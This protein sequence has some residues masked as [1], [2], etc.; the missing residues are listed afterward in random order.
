MNILH[1]GVPRVRINGSVD[2]KGGLIVITGPG[3]FKRRPNTR[4]SESIAS[5][6]LMLSHGQ[7][8]GKG[9]LVLTLHMMS[10]LHILFAKALDDGQP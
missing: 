5:R 2:K 6:S 10:C 8:L 1:K 4:D 9:V 3:R 7:D